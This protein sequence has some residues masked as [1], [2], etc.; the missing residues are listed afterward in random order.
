MKLILLCLLM[1]AHA[2]A[3][4]TQ[5]SCEAH[6]TPRVLE[7]ALLSKEARQAKLAEWWGTKK[8]NVKQY[9]M[10]SASGS[11]RWDIC[12]LL[13]QEYGDAL[14]ED[15]IQKVFSHATAISS[16]G[17][18][19]DCI[20]VCSAFVRLGAKPTA[21][22]LLFAIKCLNNPMAQ[23]LIQNGVT[24]AQAAEHRKIVYHGK[25]SSLA[26][27]VVCLSRPH[28][29]RTKG[30]AMLQTVIET[31]NAGTLFSALRAHWVE[32]VALV[33]KQLAVRGEPLPAQALS[34]AI[35]EESVECCKLLLA[36]WSS[37]YLG[38][39]SITA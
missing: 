12:L 24:I 4:D 36:A 6:E 19:D 9:P 35:V 23:F 38:A 25:P 21:D 2:V 10:A 5:N 32:A 28:L 22:Q 20:P 31:A 1:S 34:I 13:A 33:I 11:G 18:I 30:L 16:C 7:G 14:I 37:G 29:N 17:R 15:D 3:M 8:I 27:L 39:Y 26:E